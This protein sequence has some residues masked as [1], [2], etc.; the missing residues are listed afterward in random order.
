MEDLIT[1]LNNLNLKSPFEQMRDGLFSA[2]LANIIA[3]IE[4]LAEMIT[5]VKDTRNEMVKC[6]SEVLSNRHKIY[7]NPS[8]CAYL[9][10]F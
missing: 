10:H 9:A 5:S 3:T 4:S 1:S 7:I 8:N 2:D 6:Y